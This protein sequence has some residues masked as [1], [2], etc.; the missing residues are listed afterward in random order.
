MK[1]Y[2]IENIPNA[3]EYKVRVFKNN[4]VEEF[5]DIMSIN[6]IRGYC[7]CLEHFGYTC[8]AEG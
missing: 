8:K 1:Y 5:C 4:G 6:F 7:R 2:T 3:L